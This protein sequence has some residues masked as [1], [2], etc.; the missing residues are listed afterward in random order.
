MSCLLCTLDY[1]NLP[2]VCRFTAPTTRG[3]L[4]TGLGK[5]GKK[6]TGGL[7]TAIAL[8]RPTHALFRGQNDATAMRRLQAA[9]GGEAQERLMRAV[10]C[11]NDGGDCRIRKPLTA[12]P[13]HG[14]A[15]WR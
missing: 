5:S 6:N 10:R 15:A 7:R 8:S 13:S 11:N 14:G 4:F 3:L 1:I 9:V 2:C 12:A